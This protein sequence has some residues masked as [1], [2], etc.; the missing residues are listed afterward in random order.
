MFINSFRKKYGLEL[1]PTST[2]DISLGDLIWKRRHGR[3][4]LAR[5][6]MPS[7]IYNVF[8]NSDLLPMGKWEEAM[9]ALE[10][11]T[12]VSAQLGALTI[13]TTKNFSQTFPHP[14]AQ[15]I[16][17]ILNN[18]N[19][20]RYQFSELEA[21]ILSDEW[22]LDIQAYLNQLTPAQTD[23]NFNRLRPIY[24]ITQLFY[25]KLTFALDKS[26]NHK[27]EPLKQMSFLA[28]LQSFEQEKSIL[29]TFD[30]QDVPFA[31]RI[32]NLEDFKA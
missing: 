27:L 11:A 5:R 29:Y 15:K 24:I 25:G 2:A 3:P 7:H 32:E 4:R 18:E 31:M 10:S 20:Q 22:R 1:L 8:L 19:Q 26:L 21:R 13:S 12:P 16:N 17:Y 14:I 6:G 23:A 9:S 30:H 28:G